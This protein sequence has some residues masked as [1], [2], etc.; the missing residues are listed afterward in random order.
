MTNPDISMMTLEVFAQR[1]GISR[2]QAERCK[3][4]ESKSFPPLVVK[5]VKVPGSKGP[6]RIYVTV[7]QEQAW[8][9]AIP[10]E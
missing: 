7:E 8:K 4:G 3:N 1:N 9:D 6:G 5:R 2:R 10:D